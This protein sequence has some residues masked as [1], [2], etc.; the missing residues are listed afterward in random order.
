V[1][2]EHLWFLLPEKD[3]QEFGVVF[4]GVV[5]RFFRMLKRIESS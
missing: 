2:V 5:M 4:G 1:N 3:R